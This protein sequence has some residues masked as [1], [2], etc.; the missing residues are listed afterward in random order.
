LEAMACGAA[1]IGSNTTS[2]PEVIGREDAL[3]DPHKDDAIAEK[4]ELVLTDEDFRRELQHHGIEQA[5]RFSWD[6]SARWAI[7]AFEAFYAK[8]ADQPVLVK[9]AR[10]PKL[11]YISPLPP[12]RS[13]ISD[14]SAELLPELAK[15]YDIEVIV[16]QK[17][18]SDP[19]IKANCPVRSV[20]WFR[21]N[22]WSYDRVLYHF[23]NSP[24]HTH[25]FDLLQPYPGVVVL[26]DF[27]LSSVL[28]HEEMTGAI[29][30]MWTRALYQSHGYNAV[31]MRFSKNGIEQAKWRYPCN[32]QVLQNALG[33]IVHSDYSKRLAKK[34][35]G[36]NAACDWVVIPLLRVPAPDA[37]RLKARRQLGLAHDTFLVCSFGMLG[38]TKLNHRLLQAWLASSLSKDGRC[39]LVFVGQNHDG[40]YGAQLLKTI[41]ESGLERR[42]RITGWVDADT[43]RRYLQAA[44]VA[45]Q[46]RT[47]S[48][49]E[50]SGTVLDCMNH[51]LATIVNAHGSMAELPKDAVWMLPDEFEE[52]ELVQALETLW[53][54]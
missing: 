49:G 38:P 29:P 18:V 16:A 10:R 9:P 8:K 53:K 21:Q 42:I 28:A 26:H 25:M 32:L 20:E 6:E 44:D 14:Y 22:A 52:K 4:L 41:K 15:Y 23:G 3:F 35:Y 7:A 33:I 40:D 45:V 37:D 17:D 12:E 5:K 11:A 13:G 48:R 50:T 54:D 2:I 19:W 30:G 31:Q 34:W 47:L 51:G 43:F 36:E 24:F 1:V 46:L 39:N 27:F